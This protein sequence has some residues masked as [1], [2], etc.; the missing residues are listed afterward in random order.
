MKATFFEDAYADVPP[1]QRGRLEQ[2]L[3]RLRVQSWADPSDTDLRERIAA[4][5]AELATWSAP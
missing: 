1:T 4:L 5:E 3:R 2:E